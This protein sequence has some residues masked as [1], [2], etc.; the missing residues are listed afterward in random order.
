[1]PTR[2]ASVYSSKVAEG[3]VRGMLR[4]GAVVRAVLREVNASSASGGRV[5]GKGLRAEVRAVRGA[6]MVE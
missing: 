5:G 4:R 3:P 1:M 2:E 6:A